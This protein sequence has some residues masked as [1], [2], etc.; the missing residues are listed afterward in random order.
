MAFF[1]AFSLFLALQLSMTLI[2]ES[3]DPGGFR[4][5]LAHPV[6]SPA[7]GN[8][9]S[10]GESLQVTP[11]V[12]ML[13]PFAFARAAIAPHDCGVPLSTLETN[14]RSVSRAKDRGFHGASRMELPN[15]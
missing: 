8:N 12:L 10:F 4:F 7:R 15:R 11:T 2:C 1:W 6:E 13:I 3:A 14:S 5:R 9:P